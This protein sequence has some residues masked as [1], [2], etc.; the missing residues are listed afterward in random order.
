MKFALPDFWPLP[1]DLILGRTGPLRFFPS[2]RLRAG[3]RTTHM[4]VLGITG[5]GKSKLLEHCLLQ[6]LLAGRGCGV[7]DP[8]T[9]LARDLLTSLYRRGFFKH[10]RNRQRILYLDPSRPEHQLPFNVLADSANP[11]QTAIHIVEAFRRAWPESLREAPRFSNVLLASL[12][13]LI[14][15]RLTL[16]HLPRLLTDKRFREAQLE[17]VADP[18]VVS[19]F[20]DRLDRWG[21]EEPLM[22]ESILNKASAFTLNPLLRQILGQPENALD[23]RKIMDEG[24]ILIADLGR[25][26]GETRRLLGSLIVTGIEQAALS[27]KDEPARS[28]RPFFFYIDE[29]QDF[30]ANEGSATTL[31][32]ILS[33]T[34]KFGL[35]LTLAH[36]TLGQMPGERLR[37]ALGNIG[38]K[39]V[40]AADRDDAEVMARKLFFASGENIKHEVE[41]EGQQDRTHPVYYSLQEDWEQAIQAIQNLRP[42][43]CLVR[44]PGRNVVKLHTIPVPSHPESERILEKL[45][46]LL[47]PPAS[48]STREWV[49]AEPAPRA[50]EK[51][52][53]VY[54]EPAPAGNR[55]RVRVTG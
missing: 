36:Q 34:R 49:Q 1:G 55:A 13:T 18:E 11:Y 24:R 15:N 37:A 28:R 5:Q 16:V 2:F 46:P 38:T 31:S 42:R 51:G 48:H 3:H 30:C 21:R 27:R 4:Y 9:D 43:T 12:L 17:K 22:L 29:F 39:I 8:H 32:Q 45:R 7:I 14:P 25:C 53:T 20:H 26:D 52:E 19:V 10:A 23:F 33:E 6:D 54:Y 50:A 44:T 41:N 47:I 40:F 35:H